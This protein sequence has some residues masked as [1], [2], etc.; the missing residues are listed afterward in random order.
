VRQRQI[1]LAENLKHKNAIYLD[2]KF[3]VILREVAARRRVGNGEI[4]LL[5]AL[6]ECV[7]KGK[8]FCPVSDSTFAE[9]LKQSD[10]ITRKATARL[11]D[12]LS[13]GVAV[14]P[15]ESRV[16]TELAHFIHAACSPNNLHPPEHLVWSKL[17]YV[18]GFVHPRQAGL[19]EESEGEI[20]KQFFDYMWTISMSEL[21]DRIGN[22]TP[23]RPNFEQLAAVLNAGNARHVSELLSFKSAYLAEIQGVVD[24]FAGTALDIVGEMFEK[25]SGYQGRLSALQRSAREREFKN[26]LFAAFKKDIAKD[27]LRTLHIMACMHAFVRWNK[28]QQLKANDFFDFRHATAALGYCDAFFTERSMRAMISAKHMSLDQRYGCRVI[29]GVDDAINYLAGLA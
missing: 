2:V 19:D 13:L 7:S 26:L 5:H 9:L 16:A 10:P 24:L 4:R 18:L 14:I 22:A 20:Q 12:E 23:P 17:S 6:R 29:A 15:F 1:E 3:W 8:V 21:I 27:S 11:I 28:Q 25:S